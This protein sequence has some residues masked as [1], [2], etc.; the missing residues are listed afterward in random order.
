[1]TKTTLNAADE[2]WLRDNYATARWTDMELRLSRSRSTVCKMA[3]ALGLE[4]ESVTKKKATQQFS[5]SKGAQVRKDTTKT[6][7]R[8]PPVC[9]ATVDHKKYPYIPNEL[10]YRR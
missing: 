8:P 7:V 6:I 1:M 9:A 3:M 10:S 5:I 4:R 2:T